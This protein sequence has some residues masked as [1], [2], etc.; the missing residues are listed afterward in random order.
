VLNYD[1]TRQRALLSTLGLD[2]TDPRELAGALAGALALALGA[3]ALVTLRPRRPSDPVERAYTRFCERL[4]ALG[5]PRA[6]DE[7]ASRY[8]HR[9]DRLLEPSEAAL[10]RDIVASYNRLRYDPHTA[11]PDRVRHLRRLVDAF[12]P[13]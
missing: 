9:V 3:V 12:K 4:A 6:R 5:A 10:A 1:R 7:T 2:A 11:T 8:L 13:R